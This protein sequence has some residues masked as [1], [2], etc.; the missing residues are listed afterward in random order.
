[1]KKLMVTIFML[2]MT[3]ASTANA[4]TARL[5]V[6]H[7]AADPAA[8][9]VDVYVNDALLLN[10]FD[11]REATPFID[12]PAE[13]ELSIAIAPPNSDSSSDAIAVFN[14]TLADMQTYVIMANGV[15]NPMMFSLNPDSIAIAFNLFPVD[16]IV[17]S[18]PQGMVK[19]IGF[20]GATDAPAVDIYPLYE[21]V[22]YGE[23]SS[24]AEIPADAYTI[25]IRPAGSPNALVAYD[26]N[27]SGLGGGSAVAFASGF[28]NPA[29]N[30][31]GEA[32]GL[33]AAL[34]NGTVV[35]FPAVSTKAEDGFS[36]LPKDFSLNQNYPNPFNPSTT[37]SFSLA[38]PSNVKLTVF[39]M[40]GQEVSTLINEQLE[41]GSHQVEFNGTGVPS[42][43]YFYRIDAGS[44]SQTQ[45]MTLLK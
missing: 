19:V 26:V 9:T 23:F 15:L 3:V 35:E 2:A 37:I 43:I 4:Q 21:D 10:D 38:E 17:E 44:H 41:A 45:K 33:F 27:L 42:G 22:A 30:Q 5:Q 7:N 1:M 8:A 18:A 34:P 24:Y 39:N 14:T 11:F 6:I 25:E 31:N 12:V 28:L 36:G 29:N 40:L 32:F 16:N 20:H 13:T